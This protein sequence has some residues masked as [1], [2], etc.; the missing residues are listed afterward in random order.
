MSKIGD[1]LDENDT[2]ERGTPAKACSCQHAVPVPKASVVEVTKTIRVGTLGEPI[3][4][5]CEPLEAIAEPLE[6]IA[7]PPSGA[8]QSSSCLPYVH[9]QRSPQY[10]ACMTR[11]RQMGRIDDSN[12]LYDLIKLDMGSED[13][14]NLMVILLDTQLYC[15][16]VDKIARGAR[17]R[18]SVPIPDV[19][20]LPLMAGATAFVIAHNHPSGNPTPSKADELLT[21]ALRKAAKQVEVDLFDHLVVGNDG[22]YSFRANRWKRNGKVEKRK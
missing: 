8:P 4:V 13:Q 15:R 17:D 9:V 2:Y 10:N 14:E 20:R 11:A 19:L 12:K 6:A 18:V 7:E 5:A 22:Y 3:N 16:G 21:D 1:P